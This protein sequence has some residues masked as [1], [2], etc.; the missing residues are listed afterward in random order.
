MT[1]IVVQTNSASIHRHDK[2]LYLYMLCSHR[3]TLRVE[4][5]W[6]STPCGVDSVGVR[7]RL[8]V[9]TSC[10][11]KH[12]KSPLSI[13][14]RNRRGQVAATY[15]QGSMRPHQT[16]AKN[17]KPV[18]T[19]PLNRVGFLMGVMRPSTKSIQSLKGTAMQYR[20]YELNGVRTYQHLTPVKI[21]P[22]RGP[23]GHGRRIQG[24]D[25]PAQYR[26]ASHKWGMANRHARG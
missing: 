6:E 17:R 12:G 16:G 13:A 22:R 2:R 26:S 9:T 7:N 24:G 3:A 8:G 14:P 23:S 10:N 20:V 5:R 25:P 1:R 11:A 19:Y 15:I 4:K 18:S 21:T